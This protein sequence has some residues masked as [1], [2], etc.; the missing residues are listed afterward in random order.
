MIFIKKTK[1]ELKRKNYNETIPKRNAINY[2]NITKLGFNI[3]LLKFLNMTLI[4]DL[5][6]DLKKRD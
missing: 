6:I 3:D 1:S 2:E 5:L 4:N